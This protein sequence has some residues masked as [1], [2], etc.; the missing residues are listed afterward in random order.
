MKINYS[1]KHLI[2]LHAAS[3]FYIAFNYNSE[4]KP[5]EKAATKAHFEP[6]LIA[7]SEQF[8]HIF[9]SYSIFFASDVEC[10]YR[11]MAVNQE[12]QSPYKKKTFW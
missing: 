12:Q 2:L 10:A 7:I 8:L 11:T 4:L 6:A 5:Y 9:F 3:T 1:N